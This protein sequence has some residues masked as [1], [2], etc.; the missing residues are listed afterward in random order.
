MKPEQ[1]AT[2]PSLSGYVALRN[3]SS[4]ERNRAEKHLRLRVIAHS[5]CVRCC[6]YARAIATNMQILLYGRA[7]ERVKVLCNTAGLNP[8]IE[9][10]VGRSA[11]LDVADIL[12]YLQEV[13][14]V[15]R[16]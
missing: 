10:Q 2:P 4:L 15:K 11:P 13:C 7:C 14:A 8:V 3:T 12:G 1:N 6:V 9:D 16:E 5:A